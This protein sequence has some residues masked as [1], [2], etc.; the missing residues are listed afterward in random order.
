MGA[1]RA[2]N[3]PDSETSPGPGLAWIKAPGPRRAPVQTPDPQLVLCSL[4]LW[5]EPT[6]PQGHGTW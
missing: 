6:V 2:R 3:R 4:H 1:C 5:V